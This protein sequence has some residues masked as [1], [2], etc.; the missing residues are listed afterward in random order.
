M[1]TLPINTSYERT[2]LNTAH[3]HFNKYPRE[4]QLRVGGRIISDICTNVE[5]R[6]LCVQPTGSGK[7][8]LFQTIASFLKGVTL[9]LSPLLSLAAD[10]VNKLVINTRG[11]DSTIIALHMDESE[12]GDDT[13]ILDLIKNLKDTSTLFLF[14]SPQCIANKFPEFF[15]SLIADGLIKFVVVD[16]VHL[17]THFGRTFRDEFN[18]LKDGLFSKLPQSMPMLFLTATCT[19]SIDV[20]FQTMIGKSITHREWPIPSIMAFGNRRTA[21]NVSYSSRPYSNMFKSIAVIQKEIEELELPKKV[22]VYSNAKKRIRQIEDKI[23]EDLDEDDDLHMIDIIEVDG[24]LTKVEKAFYIQE[25]LDPVTETNGIDLNRILVCTSGVG[26]VGIDSP[27]IRAVYRLEYPPSVIDF[28]QEMGRAGR[29][30]GHNPLDYS[31]NVYFSIDNFLHLFE[32][33]MNPDENYNDPSYRKEVVSNLMEMAKILVLSRYCFYVCIE[34]ALSNPYRDRRNDMLYRH[35]P[36]G[37]C[38]SCRN[39]SIFP[40]VN[41]VGLTKVI[42]DVFNPGAAANPNTSNG[43]G[44][45][46]LDF[47]TTRIREY[48]EANYL[49]LRSRAQGGIAPASIHQVLMILITAEIL[50]MNYHEAIKSTILSLARKSPGEAAFALMEDMFWEFITLK[51]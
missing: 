5:I 15:N 12:R 44:P 35:Y 49:I 9:C 32:R 21:I 8:L 40:K 45:F 38:P 41:R 3:K 42:F 1:N 27:D 37:F 7:S 23:G 6:Q 14:C 36:C 2:F 33:T 17:F 20:A 34:T 11:T 29:R 24:A 47:I 16:E 28:I 4:W 48:P 13:E 39:E 43:M 46:T 30:I 10:Q 25:F 22:I 50:A 18:Q 26:N 51:I 19:L 31:Y